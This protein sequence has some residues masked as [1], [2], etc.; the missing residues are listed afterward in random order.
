MKSAYDLVVP[1]TTA[2]SQFNWNQ[3]WQLTGP[4]RGSLLL[5][6]TA[7][8]RLK[9][10]ALLWRRQIL[11]SL[12]C[13]LCGIADESTLHA[14]RDCNLSR[15]IWAHLVPDVTGQIFCLR[16]VRNSGFN[17]TLH[18]GIT[19]GGIGDAG[20]MFFGSLFK[21]SGFGGTKFCSSR[22]LLRL[23]FRLL[24]IF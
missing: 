2:A 9:T 21:R 24:I 16:R 5:W 6:M 13:D 10:K 15:K 4:A 19:T 14:V 11:D 20:N 17:I 12:R 1:S 8:D 23:L 18:S 7:H 3:L 22:S